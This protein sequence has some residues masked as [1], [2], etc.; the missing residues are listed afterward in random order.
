MFSLF[1]QQSR[2]GELLS[3]RLHN[4]KTFYGAFS[5]DIRNATHEVLLESPFITMRRSS[6]I[7][8][9]F[10]NIVKRGVTVRVFT[11]HPRYHT[12]DMR[13]QAKA[14]ICILKKSGV[15]VI[16]C[17]DMRHRKVATIDGN[18]LWEGSLNFLSH[19]N[20][21]EIMRRTE[22]QVLTQ[23]MIHFLRLKKFNWQDKYMSGYEINEKDI[24]TVVSFLK[25]H[26]PENATPEKAI[27]LLG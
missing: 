18:I 1:K 2:A 13:N 26:D 20:S 11:R 10:E 6:E 14:G 24:D 4:E 3:S 12:A 22:S 15:R 16:T 23:Q 19:S 7:A 17:S 25:I 5:R 21:R 8:R 9:L 27:E